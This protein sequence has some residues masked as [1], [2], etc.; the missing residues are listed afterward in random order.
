MTEAP[1]HTEPSQWWLDVVLIAALPV[2]VALGYAVYDASV[3]L[4]QPMFRYGIHFYASLFSYGPH[5]MQ[6]YHRRRRPEHGLKWV[7]LGSTLRLFALVILLVWLVVTARPVAAGVVLFVITI[8]TF[9]CFQVVT[10]ARRKYRGR[11]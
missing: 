5:W 1:D 3:T 10:E 6:R 8:G 4:V 2:A 11:A 9:L 7:L